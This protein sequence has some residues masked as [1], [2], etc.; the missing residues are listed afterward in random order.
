MLRAVL[1]TISRKY[2]IFS[3]ISSAVGQFSLSLL[4]LPFLVCEGFKLFFFPPLI[5]KKKKSFILFK[6]LLKFQLTLGR[7]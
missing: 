7:Q 2:R 6:I 1:V 5:K 3:F 4:L